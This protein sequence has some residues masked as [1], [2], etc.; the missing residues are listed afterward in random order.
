[1]HPTLNNTI[2]ILEDHPLYAAGLKDVAEQLI[3]D[4]HVICEPTLSAGVHAVRTHQPMLVISDLHLPDAQGLT[5]LDVLRSVAPDVLLIGITGDMELLSRYENCSH[6]GTMILA[7]TDSVDQVFDTLLMQ[8]QMHAQAA[9][10]CKQTS[11]RTNN[12]WTLQMPSRTLTRKQQAVLSL[13]GQGLSN[14]E[15]ARKLQIS[16]ETVKSHAKSLYRQ[17]GVKNRTQAA[18][19]IRRLMR[20]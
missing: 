3:P 18:G 8:I 2:L 13:M 5:T 14:K 19:Q 1:M 11:V 15:I 6:D 16:P 20:A 10:P 17:L 4:A 12:V 9:R 7:K